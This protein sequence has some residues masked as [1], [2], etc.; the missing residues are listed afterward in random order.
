MTQAPLVAADATSAA[1][2]PTADATPKQDRALGLDLLGLLPFAAY[3]LIFLGAPTVAVVVGAFTDDNGHPTLDNI[4]AALGSPYLGAFGESILISS[5]T[6]VLGGVLGLAIAFAV[7]G[8]PANGFLR[9]A[10]STASGVFAYFGGVPLA[11]AFIATLGGQGLLTKWLADLGFSV[12]N[13]FLFGVGGIILVYLYFQIPLMVLVI[14][15]AIEGL[16]PQWLEA[17]RNLGA[18]RWQYWRYVGGPL[19]TPPVLGA[20]ML[21]FAN[22]FASYATAEALTNGVIPLVPIEIGNV[23][24]GNV[25][26]G[27]ENLGNALGFGMIIIVAIAMVGYTLTQRKAARWM[28]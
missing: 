2:S 25:A 17:A 10:V 8:S 1:T 21:L 28:R 6:A 15:P 19:L 27:E 16:R 26:A 23:M 4:T 9:Q 18:N 7:A 5:V 11:F 22:A 20:L 14:F 24:S 12:S 3:L 13:S